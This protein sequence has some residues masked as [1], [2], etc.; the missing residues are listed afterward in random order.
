MLMKNLNTMK[1]N[2]KQNKLSAVREAIIREQ[3]KRIFDGMGVEKIDILFCAYE[4]AK[5]VDGYH[6]DPK[7]NGGKC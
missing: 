7:Y 2:E 4:L 1:K 6:L 5:Q 3:L